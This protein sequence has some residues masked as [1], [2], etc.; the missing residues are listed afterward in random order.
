MIC[1]SDGDL[2][3]I[4]TLTRVE[5]GRT[6]LKGALDGRDLGPIAVRGDQ[7]PVQGRLDDLRRS[8]AAW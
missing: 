1:R 6:C 5:R 7:Q 8:R 2:D 3:T 4:G